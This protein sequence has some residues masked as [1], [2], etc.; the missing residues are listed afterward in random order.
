MM[1]LL[2]LSLGL[3][4]D[5]M[6]QTFP[7]EWAP[8]PSGSG[9]LVDAALD[10][11]GGGAH[12]DIVGST[13]WPAGG[14]EADSDFLYLSMRVDATPWSTAA[15][16]N[17]APGTWG[18]GLDT[19]GDLSTIEA[20]LAIVGD[21]PNLRRLENSSGDA[22]R[23]VSFSLDPDEFLSSDY[24]LETTATDSQMEG[25][26]DYLFQLAIARSVLADR[27]GVE[28]DTEFRIS[29]L[30]GS[31]FLS[32]DLDVDIASPDDSL[33]SAWTTALS[34]D[35]D[36]D[37]ISTA[38]EIQ[39]GTDPA[40]SDT[41]DDGLSD[42][43]ELNQYGTD[44][45][46][47]DSDSDGL[48]DGL[49]ASVTIALSDTNLDNGCFLVDEDPSTDTDP[50][51]EDTDEGGLID[52]D[53][54]RNANGRIDAFET[55]PNNPADDVDQNE[56]GIADA[57]ED[58][59]G[60]GGPDGD[61][62]GDGIP[63]EVEGLRD[64]DGDG[65]PDF[66]DPDSDND[67]I[68]DLEEGDL[69][70][71][72]DDIPD[73]LDL[74]SD[75][76]G[77][78]DQE[79]S[80]NLF[81]GGHFTGGACSTS[82]PPPSWLLVVLAMVVL[83]SRRRIGFLALMLPGTALAGE[84]VDAQRFLPGMGT[85]NF[86]TMTELPQDH[87]PGA[88][89]HFNYADDPLVYR[90]DGEEE[91]EVLSRVGTA[92]L[93]AW[94]TLG[95]FRVGA[96]LPLHVVSSGYGVEGFR[97]IGDMRVLGDTQLVDWGNIGLSASASLSLP[98]GAEDAWLGEQNLSARGN[99]QAAWNAGRVQALARA[100]VRTGSSAQIGDLELGSRL[101]FATGVA[102]EATDALSFS[103]ELDAEALLFNDTPGSLPAELLLGAH[104][105]LTD[106]WMLHL[107]AG[108][109]LTQGIGAP[110]F[111]AL[112]S[113]GWIPPRPQ[114]GD[115]VVAVQNVGVRVISRNTSELPIAARVRVL[116][117]PDQFFDGAPDGHTTFELPPGTHKLLVWAEGYRPTE[118]VV[119]LLPGKKAELDV[120]LEEG[121]VKIEGEQVRIYDKIFFEL[122]SS[123]I[124][125]DSFP[126]LDEVAHVLFNHP[127]L[128]LIAIEGHTDDQ[129][130]EEYNLELSLQRA[131]AVQH[132]LVRTGI[133][134][135]RLEAYGYGESVPLVLGESDDTRAANRR[136]EFHI[137][138]RKPSP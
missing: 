35:A 15:E 26:A 27:F 111:R 103:G 116:G 5:A 29:L 70:T 56:N 137:R 98:T 32:V 16:T 57:L 45:L 50:S 96:D 46:V 135:D 74:D 66:C 31:A 13:D 80:K 14:W 77:I 138:R 75:G 60:M 83:S 92:N 94:S 58:E 52:G 24:A 100:G 21:T 82:S 130:D 4:P 54:D 91:I 131:Q 22:G 20:V 2:S 133:A 51:V 1:L 9:H 87:R 78:P 37:G 47:C 95:R 126:L 119:D 64:S 102:W 101:A 120:V 110:D 79:E 115:G 67:G 38:E 68:S 44:A 3:T 17:Y 132:Y 12:L 123:E 18:F 85:T 125:Q 7:T 41:D 63:D 118:A 99:L 25:N 104:R 11:T 89:L 36:G 8:L 40:D 6:A 129:G 33:E 39:L 71:D 127:E 73:Y 53:E 114:L 69:D 90:R 19:D 128:E 93:V 122:D 55:D 108:K 30:T 105:S 65:L 113:L 62:D 112:V 106:S 43:D 48:L 10:Q 28:S 49:E 124:R 59:C 117:N 107:G 88:T 61:A 72:G 136:V 97:L 76:D 42:P 134:K 34:I 121:R 81:T 23:T 84:P 109:G 86:W